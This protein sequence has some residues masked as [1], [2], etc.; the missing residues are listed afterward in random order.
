MRQRLRVLWI[1][2]QTAYL[3]NILQTLNHSFV[4]NNGYRRYETVQ[5]LKNTTEFDFGM[6]HYRQHTLSWV[7]LKQ[8]ALVNYI[9]YMRILKPW[10]FKPYILHTK[11]IKKGVCF[12]RSDWK[13][14]PTEGHTAKYWNSAITYS[15]VSWTKTTYHY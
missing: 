7:L 9:F 4:Q 12:L 8:W 6:K 10:Q 13:V 11:I 5:Y 2:E 15:T 14:N 1:M 3:F